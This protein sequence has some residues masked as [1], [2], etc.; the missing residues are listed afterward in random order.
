ME[1]IK[2]EEI[3]LDTLCD[4]VTLSRDKTTDVENI[5]VE[6]KKINCSPVMNVIKGIYKLFCHL[7]KCF[8]FKK[9]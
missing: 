4:A 3:K 9:E 6:C 1:E 7:I 8:K 5:Q 2:E